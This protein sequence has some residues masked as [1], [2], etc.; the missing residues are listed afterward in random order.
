MAIRFKIK[1]YLSLFL[2]FFI[3]SLYRV[4]WSET[5]DVQKLRERITQFYTAIQ[6][7]ELDKAAEF[8]VENARS[9]FKSQPP[10]RIQGFNI[11]EIKLEENKQ[12]ATVIVAVKI[13]AP[14][15]FRPF[16]LPM[17]TR[18]K[19]R[20]GDWF[21]DI[22]DP[23]Q[24]IDDKFREYFSKKQEARLR[25][26][27][28]SPPLPLEVKFD[29]DVIDF[30]LAAKG[31]TLTLRFPFTNVS[32]KE[33]RIEKVYVQ[34]QFMKDG[35]KKVSF[36][37]GEKGE[38]VVDLDTSPLFRDVDQTIFVEFEPIQEIIPLRTYGKVFDAKDLA[39]HKTH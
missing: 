36:K 7:N 12:S 8:I 21:N 26:P 37:P 13:I 38:V 33:I 10:G 11:S 34:D 31:T 6:M 14:N 18:W 15:I 19:L 20:G 29:R 22:N 32:P 9:T 2:T 5:D 27:P 23:P 3:F 4:G 39:R 30:G 17:Y 24:T 25:R 1:G 28:N 16:D 35:T